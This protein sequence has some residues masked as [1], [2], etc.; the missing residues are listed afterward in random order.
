MGFYTDYIVGT[1]ILQRL[2]E[3]LNDVWMNEWMNGQMN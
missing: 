3:R 2:G 1:H